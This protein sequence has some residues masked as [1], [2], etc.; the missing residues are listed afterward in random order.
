MSE[1][2]FI[3][4]ISLLENLHEQQALIE[5]DRLEYLS[6]EGIWKKIDIE[7]LK[8]VPVSLYVG[9]SLDDDMNQ[10]IYRVKYDLLLPHINLVPSHTERILFSMNG[11]EENPYVINYQS[12]VNDAYNDENVLVRYNNKGANIFSLIKHPVI[13]SDYIVKNRK[14]LHKLVHVIYSNIK[15]EENKTYSLEK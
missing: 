6:E 13:M 11:E 2:D 14:K 9:V 5:L 3:H 15:N 7:G 4:K 8:Y 10:I 12:R 1:S